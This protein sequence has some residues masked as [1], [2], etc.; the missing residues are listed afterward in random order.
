MA[1]AAFR[2]L[3]HLANA[4]TMV[5]QLVSFSKPSWQLPAF[6][7]VMERVGFLEVKLPMLANAE[8]GRVWRSV[9]NRKWY[10]DQKG[11]LFPSKEVVL[12]HHLG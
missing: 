1:K 4:D 9:P 7:K 6:L 11:A 8:D 3:A 2:S 12:F 5:V 10:A